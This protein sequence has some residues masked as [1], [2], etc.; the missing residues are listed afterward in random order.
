M[1]VLGQKEEEDLEREIE[2]YCRIA[3]ANGSMLS[4]DQLTQLIDVDA[5]EADVE[6]TIRS[7]PLLRSKLMLRSGYVIER[8]MARAPE[9]V[10]AEIEEEMENH[11]RAVENLRTA[12]T[13]A[14]SLSARS[15]MTA[16]G[17]TNSYLSAREKDDI[18]LFCIARK[19][20]MWILMLEA[21]ARARV[22]GLSHRGTPTIC[23][24]FV[25][26]ERWAADELGKPRDAIFA[27]DL[28]TSKVIRGRQAYN[29]LTRRASWMKRFFPRL[30]SAK[31][32][33]KPEGLDAQPRGRT[34][35]P[36]RMV[37]SYLFATLGRYI[38]LKAWLLN[39]R[40]AKEGLFEHGFTTDI[41]RD[42][43][44]YESNRY[45]AI[46]RMYDSLRSS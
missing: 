38:V 32:S 5:S 25:M 7:A 45:R 4:V 6:E 3:L 11:R 14:L 23:L 21:L 16:V 19:D 46:R 12:R 27:R 28:L 31:L 17:G 22:F 15:L 1:L 26:D 13:F 24:S 10:Q 20:T 9:Q 39:R 43:L 8:S 41:G 37:N 40:L 34:S 18:D 33:M 30:Y 2:T 35:L 42:H 29:D 36:T 44:I